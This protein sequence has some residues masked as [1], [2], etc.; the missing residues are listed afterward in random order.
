[1]AIIRKP[2]THGAPIR[3]DRVRAKPVVTIVMTDVEIGYVP[4]D[5]PDSKPTL[6]C[7][8]IPYANKNAVWSFTNAEHYFDI[9]IPP[10]H[11]MTQYKVAQ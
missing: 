4:D 6:I 5:S 8:K 3:A 2:K 11:H 1:M 7:M 9:F 10:K